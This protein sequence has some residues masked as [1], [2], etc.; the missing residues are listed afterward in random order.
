MQEIGL[1]KFN[2][3][4]SFHIPF[5]THK[6]YY[7]HSKILFFI[8]TEVQVFQIVERLHNS[9]A[10]EDY[11]TGLVT[12]VTQLFNYFR[13]LSEQKYELEKSVEIARALYEKKIKNGGLYHQVQLVTDSEKII[14]ESQELVKSIGATW[15]A[16][17]DKTKKVRFSSIVTWK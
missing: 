3:C 16:D 11:N 12:L 10:E 6:P 5:A 14:T 2:A 17:Q 13:T 1:N 15:Q 7:S 9:L 8:L 4:V